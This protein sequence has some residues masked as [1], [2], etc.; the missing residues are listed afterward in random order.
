MAAKDIKE[1]LARK[2]AENNQRHADATQETEF[3]VGRQYKKIA[4]T[5]IVPNPYQPRQRFN[6]VDISELAASI[7]ELGL[8][9]PIS[10]R[11]KDDKYQLIAG[12][13]RF[14]AYQLLGKTHI[15]SLVMSMDDAEVALLG[16]AENLQRQDL[17]DFEIGQALRQIETVFSNKKKLAEA[18]GI[19]REDMY[20]YYAYE[21]FPKSFLS[22]LATKPQMIGRTAAADIKRFLL[23]LTDEEF[24]IAEDALNAAW[25]L[26]LSGE[27]TQNKIVEYVQR[28][29]IAPK[30]R[31]VENKIKIKQGR[32]IVGSW[33]QTSNDV[34]IKLKAKF[35]TPEQKQELQNFVEN[36]FANVEKS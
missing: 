20:R 27:I 22:L 12:E 33:Q 29:L 35:L 7:G 3:D 16:L 21:A 19:N 17:S 2:L 28:L 13:R 11:K 1:L 6:D 32:R 26:L 14:K 30:I 10:V 36:L 4:I 15:E 25:S 31:Q 5:D 34:V 9:Q 23:D 18:V 24:A 8:L